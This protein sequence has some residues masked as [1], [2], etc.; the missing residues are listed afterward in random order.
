[1]PKAE[2]KTASGLAF[3]NIPCQLLL[4]YMGMHNAHK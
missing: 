3:I 1:M 2:L 4:H